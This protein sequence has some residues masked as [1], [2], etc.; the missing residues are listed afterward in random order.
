MHTTEEF[1]AFGPWIDEVHTVGDLPRLYRDAG[2][3][4]AAHRLVLKVPRDIERRNANAA[5]HL[6]DYLIALDAETLTVLSRVG[7]TYE[8][9]RLPLDRVM[10]IQ[11]SVR[12]L[13]GVLTVHATDGT[14]VTVS[15]NGSAAGPIRNLIRLLRQGYLPQRVEPPIPDPYRIEPRLD[16]EDT[17]LLTDY[18]HLVEQEPQLQL[19]NVSVRRTVTPVATAE[20]LY[21]RIWPIVLHASITVADDRE[22]QI[23]H[24]RDW[25][26][27]GGD[28]LSLA[29]TILPRARV[30][31]L[32]A[33][34]HDRYQD[35]HVLA[36]RAGTTEF[37]FPVLAGPLS[38]ELISSA[39]KKG[40][41][42]RG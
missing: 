30:G 13:N 37:G 18:R 14:A 27:P 8:T 35:V 31:E 41:G 36:V 25:F 6:Y 33:Y 9:V 22:I 2:L 1:D 23:I 24:R 12:L 26:T 34:P 40:A 29:R 4:P 16:R 5:M 42:R 19:L 3:D 11:D 15:Y 17:G 20:R 10:A 32:T 38:A 39:G 7:D 28:D 21:R